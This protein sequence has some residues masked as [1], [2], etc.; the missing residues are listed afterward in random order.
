MRIITLF[1]VCSLGLVVACGGGSAAGNRTR[2]AVIPKGTNHEFWKSIHAGAA[3]AAAELDVELLWKGPTREDDRDDQIKVVEDMISRGMDG[4]VVA[5]LDDR[6]LVRPLKDADSE[7][8]PVIVIDSGVEWD[9]MVSFIATDNYRGGVLGALELGAR[10]GGA[11][12]ALMMRYQE[13][14]AGTTRREAGFIA[15]MAGQF[16]AIEIVSSNQY[17]GAT[18]ESGRSFRTPRTDA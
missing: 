6:A 5:P 17:A 9:G 14:S 8:I 4:I 1:A 12:R 2:I 18:T 13:G 7:G 10:M 16:P 11:G 3:K 15:T